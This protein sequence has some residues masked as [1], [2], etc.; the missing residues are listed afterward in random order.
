MCGAYYNV[1]TNCEDLV[2]ETTRE[3]VK[4][5]AERLRANAQTMSH[6]VLA[7]LEQRATNELRQV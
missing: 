5:E 7:A 1:I 2:D 3:K 6:T 4:A